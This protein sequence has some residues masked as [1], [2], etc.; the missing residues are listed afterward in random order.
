[1]TRNRP[2]PSSVKGL[3]R[4]PIERLN[5]HIEELLPGGYVIRDDRSIERDGNRN[6]AIWIRLR[7]PRRSRVPRP[8]QDRYPCGWEAVAATSEK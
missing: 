1:M 7:D 8:C 3:V 4:P 6:V 2:R 5:V